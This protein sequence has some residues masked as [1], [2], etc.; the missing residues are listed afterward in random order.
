MHLDRQ[1]GFFINNAF[2][3]LERSEL[4]AVAIL[5]GE[6]WLRELT[7]KRTKQL[8]QSDI[9]DAL[10]SL[11]L[12]LPGSRG[13]NQEEDLE[14]LQIDYC[15]LLIGPKGHVSPVESVWVADQFQSKAVDAMKSFFD[16][17]SGYQP[18]DG[19]HD[20]IGVQLDFAGHLLQ[21]ADQVGENFDQTNE[22]VN[23]FV[24]KRLVWTTPFLKEAKQRAE[25]NFYRQL[26]VATQQWLSFFNSN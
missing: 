22:L 24:Q 17:L 5:L 18:P 2:N 25:T 6:F 4:G 13:E 14:R 11:P 16:L 20:H 9:A 1:Q 8:S 12:Y 26:A 10:T 7:A 3:T 15:Q 19:F 21:A 23:I